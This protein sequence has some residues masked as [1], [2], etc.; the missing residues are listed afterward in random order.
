VVLVSTSLIFPDPVVPG[1]L[2][3]DTVART[4]VKLALAVVLVGV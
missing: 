1:W 4:Q 2:I 3:P